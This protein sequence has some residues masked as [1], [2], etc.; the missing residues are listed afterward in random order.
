MPSN[1]TPSSCK[2]KHAF[3]A[4]GGKFS[5]WVWHSFD[6]VVFILHILWFSI[7]SMFQMVS[8]VDFSRSLRYQVSSEYAEL[9][10]YFVCFR[11][12]PTLCYSC[13]FC[14]TKS[15]ALMVRIKPNGS[16]ALLSH[17]DAMD[18]LMAYGWDGFIK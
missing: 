3:I 13:C 9:I 1:I 8:M 7:H 11:T 6:K 15:M 17:D 12:H 14:V 10:L 4:S 2:H 18:D 16:Q 5:F